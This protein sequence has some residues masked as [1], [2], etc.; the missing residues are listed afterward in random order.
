MA[1]TQETVQTPAY[2]FGITVDAPFD[3]TLSRVTEALKTEGFGVLTMIDVKQTMK[4]K[5]NVEFEQYSILGVCNP[6]LAHRALET[7]HNV[8]LLL[9]CNVVVHEAYGTD[10]AT[11]TR[12]DIADPVAM[13]GIIQNPEMQ[14]LANEARTRLERV[15][16]SLGTSK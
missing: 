9:P 13:L 1:N 3:E 5:L 10:A 11:R 16:A 8:G 6:Q 15:V 4:A 7:D 12:V 2:G 14:A